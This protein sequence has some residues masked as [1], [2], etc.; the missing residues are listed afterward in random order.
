MKPIIKRKN[1][2]FIQ[3]IFSPSNKDKYKGS[4]PIIYRSSLELKAFR[5][6]DSNPNII[7][8][9][10]ESVVIPYYYPFTNSVRKYFIDIVALLKNPKTGDFKKLLIEIKPYRYT[11]PPVN[12]NKKS[13]KTL[14]YEQQ[15]YVI[16]QSKWSA[17][18]QWAE[19]KGYTFLILTEKNY[20]GIN[21]E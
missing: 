17:A 4:L 19:K 15:Q 5:D 20:F 2:K 21:K 1:P 16:N 18:R 10:S 6:M 9:G 13:Q 11:L 3:G 7:S 14:L 12:S 8:W